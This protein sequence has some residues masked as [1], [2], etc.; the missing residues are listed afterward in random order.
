MIAGYHFAEDP[1][2]A[3]L[4]KFVGEGLSKEYKNAFEDGL[5]VNTSVIVG[6]DIDAKEARSDYRNR[7]P[8]HPMTKTIW[9]ELAYQLY[10]IE[11]YRMIQE[12]DQDQQ[13]VG[14]NQ[15]IRLFNSDDTPSLI[16]ID[17]IADYLAKASAEN[18]GSDS[19]LA[20]QTTTFFSAL[21]DA[22][23]EVDN[24]TVIY[25]IAD[26]AFGDRAEEIKEVA[27]EKAEE[28]NELG[29]RQHKYITPTE[30]DEV[31]TVLRHRLFDDVD[32]DAS[33]DIAD[34][35]YQLYQETTKPLPDNVSDTSYRDRIER[36]YPFHPEVLETLTG[37][38]DSISEFQKTRGA[39]KLLA[40]AVYH[41]WNNR[42]DEYD[43]HLIRIY[44][45]T[46]A[47]TGIRT[48]LRETFFDFV[49]LDSAVKQDIY[50]EDGDSHAQIEDQGWLDRGHPAIGSHLC[51]T[52][53]WNS[54]V[55]GEQATGVTRAEMYV[56]VAHPDIEFSNYEDA[57][58]SLTSMG[59]TGC[60]YLY[61]EDKI[62]F[63]SEPNLN[64][65]IKE[66][67]ENTPPAQAEDKFDRVL[68]A[69]KGGGQLNVID[70]PEGPDEVPDDPRNPNLCV[71][72]YDTV[73][74]DLDED[75]G[76]PPEKIQNLYEK[77][78]TKSGGRVQKRTYKN[79]VLFLCADSENF[80]RAI[81]TATKFE[82]IN[83]ILN[84][85]Q[86]T[87][88][89]SEDQED[90]LKDER[91]TSANALS[92]AV[93]NVYRHL[94]YV[95]SDGELKRI[96]IN[97]TESSGGKNLDEAVLDAMDDMNRLIRGSDDPKG[98]VWFEQKLWQSTRNRMS[99]QDL[100][101]QFGKKPGLPLL[102][103]SSPLRETVARMVSEAGYAYWDG[104]SESGYWDG[105]GE[106][107][108]NG[109]GDL[110]NAKNLSQS[111]S[112]SNV[113]I[114][115]NQYLY[116]NIDSLLEK[117]SGQVEVR[118]VEDKDEDETEDE[119]DKKGDEG[120]DDDGDDELTVKKWSATTDAVDA[121]R[122]FSEVR[123]QGVSKAEDG[124]NAGI[125]KLTIDVEENES[126]IQRSRFHLLKHTDLFEEEY[127]DKTKVGMRYNAGGSM[128][129]QDVEFRTEFEGPV[130]AF[131]KVDD[132]PE[133]ISKETKKKNV[134][135]NFNVK[136][137][138]PEALTDEEDDIL[139]KLMD[140]F[141]D[142]TFMIQ[143]RGEGVT[144]VRGEE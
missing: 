121:H 123:T 65:I 143:V 47:D 98:Q 132:S 134:D 58:D 99:T 72:H 77:T 21:F 68:D 6:S 92:E 67:K 106:P 60:Y 96:T 88:D 23:T 119:D 83:S 94:F 126:I 144:A 125:L 97:P 5:E 42:P 69:I 111:I 7:D 32:E 120:G 26:T 81:D 61:D 24:V 138:E 73:S 105:K 104:S 74:I 28:I 124:E 27:E 44:D 51:T 95:G 133:S 85:N 110:S 46:P 53:L 38:V 50:S 91:D 8:D 86:S 41:L 107:S 20:E 113:T 49:D 112:S 135:V 15:L 56:N 82:A 122:A 37:K 2:S 137:P 43:R 71:M 141:E 70:Y 39:L 48:E 136:L 127:N 140:A 18:V 64:R 114:D 79:Y 117:H 25:S 59:E 84:D 34:T 63:K 9:G 13:A 89:L 35:Y 1:L 36:E 66:R 11:G 118:I 14:K 12:Y 45:L 40:R 109:E 131:R 80:E 75:G 52:A 129:G 17:E 87:A 55:F 116:E 128:D 16:L 139:A 103:D 115:E 33:S 22:V 93:S 142:E 90:E 31:G 29:T 62:K 130:E 3:N 78:A 4:G 57:L 19:T 101:E 100:I 54:L 102:L 30:N 76:E 108:W 10:G